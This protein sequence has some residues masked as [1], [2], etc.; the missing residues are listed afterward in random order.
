LNICSIVRVILAEVLSSIDVGAEEAGGSGV[1]NVTRTTQFDSPSFLSQYSN[2]YTNILSV[3]RISN[4]AGIFLGF[5]WP[6][7]MRRVEKKKWIFHYSSTTTQY[8]KNLKSAFFR[9]KL[10]KYLLLTIFSMKMWC[11]E[12]I[13]GNMDKEKQT[14]VFTYKIRKR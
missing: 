9:Y 14:G 2:F 11:C 1:E 8:F 6:L 5:W 13:P 7:K 10:N 3:N 12:S 4:S